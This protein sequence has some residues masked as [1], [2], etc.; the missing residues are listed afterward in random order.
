MYDWTNCLIS[1]V[2]YSR[3]AEQS[4]RNHNSEINAHVG[5]DMNT[6]CRYLPTYY[7]TYLLC[8]IFIIGRKNLANQ[9]SLRIDVGQNSWIYHAVLDF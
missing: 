9:E 7:V 6:H 3:E 1:S 8:G 4:S 2:I 5:Y